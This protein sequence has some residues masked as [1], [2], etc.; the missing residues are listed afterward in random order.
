MIAEHTIEGNEDHFHY[1][2][3]VEAG[4]TVTRAIAYNR[5][6]EEIASVETG[7]G[8]PH[9]NREEAFL[10]I[11]SAIQTILSDTGIESCRGIL[12]GV[13]GLDE[14]QSREEL[15]EQYADLP[16]PIVV[17]NDAQLAYYAKLKHEDGII[18]VANIGSILFAKKDGKFIR[19]GG[20]GDRLG[21][22]GSSF[23]I[24]KKAVQQMLKRKEEG[25]GPSPLDREL[26]ASFGA[27]NVFELVRNFY[28]NTKDYIVSHAAVIT[29]SREPEAIALMEDAGRT[30][31]TAIDRLA[32]QVGFGEDLLLGSNGTVMNNGIIAQTVTESLTE[33]GYRVTNVR[34]DVDPTIGA[35]HYFYGQ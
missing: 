33:A 10:N 31:A 3:G 23:D 24:V 29:R 6:G 5:N 13:A 27:T 2:V 1:T 8:N 19:H 22:E 34:K 12:L 17:V 9:L 11:E 26:L 18:A 35:Y 21:D 28:A 25:H 30:I 4:G 7:F 14:T 32:R 20:W 15:E 16:I